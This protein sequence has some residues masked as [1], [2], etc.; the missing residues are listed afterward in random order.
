MSNETPRRDQ[1]DK[2]TPAELAIRNAVA[3]VLRLEPIVE[4]Q[5]TGILLLLQQA[6][7]KVADFVDG[8]ETPSNSTPAGGYTPAQDAELAWLRRTSAECERKILAIVGTP[9]PNGGVT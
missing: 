4:G 9:N 7:S 5:F 2:L 6:R 3:E 8:V 1:L